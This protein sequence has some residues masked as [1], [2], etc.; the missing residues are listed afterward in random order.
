MTKTIK[1]LFELYKP[2]PAG[3]KAFVDKHVTI[4]HKD[5]NGNGDDVF[6]ASNIKK[7][8]RKKERHGYDAGEDEKVYEDVNEQVTVTKKDHS[9]G[10]MITVHDGAHQSFPLHPEHQQKIAGMSKGDKISF[11][12]ETGK[13]VHAE[14]TGSLVHLKY[15]DTNRTASVGFHHFKEDTEVEGLPELAEALKTTTGNLQNH[16][17]GADAVKKNKDGTHTIARSFFYRSGSTSEGH[18]KRISDG[19]DKIGIKHEV[20]DHGTE[21]YKPFRG[22]AS[23]WKQ[24][25]HWVKVRI[26]EGQKIHED[27]EGLDELSKQTLGS[28]VNKSAQSMKKNAVDLSDPDNDERD[29]YRAQIKRFT[30]IKNREKGIGRAVSKLTKEDIV[31]RAIERYL[32]DLEEWAPKSDKEKLILRLEDMKEGHIMQLLTLFDQLDEDN[33]RIMLEKCETP[34]GIVE[35]LNFAIENRG[36]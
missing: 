5:A 13:T 20:V 19:L 27:V 7:T 8:D 36:E 17:I 30:T 12:N 33:Q 28:Y 16:L 18:A 6:N 15:G 14:R 35:I 2:K 29:G 31:N 21:D 32:P 3:E 11:K 1:D 4:K 23:V 34:E 9:W 10:K 24:N 25:H 22:G 26:P